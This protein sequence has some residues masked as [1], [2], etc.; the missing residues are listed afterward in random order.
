MVSGEL[1]KGYKTVTKAGEKLLNNYNI[2][3]S[4]TILSYMLIF[5]PGCDTICSE[6]QV[7]QRSNIMIYMI[8]LHYQDPPVTPGDF[9]SACRKNRICLRSRHLKSVFCLSS[10]E[11]KNTSIPASV[12]VGGAAAKTCARLGCSAEKSQRDFFDGLYQDPPVTPGDFG[13]L[14][15]YAGMGI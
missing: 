3:F 8:L 10:A 6:T 15:V 13:F 1:R 7:T 12:R 11:A 14:R 2:R 4:V 5:P 9:G